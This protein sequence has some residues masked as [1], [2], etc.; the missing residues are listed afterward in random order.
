MSELPLRGSL[1]RLEFTPQ[2]R[3][4]L[5]RQ[6]ESPLLNQDMLLHRAIALQDSG[7]CSR[8]F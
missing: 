8:A 1:S 3:Q 6:A 2:W 4:H 7:S 5:H